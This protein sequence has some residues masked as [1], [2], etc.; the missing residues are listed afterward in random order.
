MYI[1]DTSTGC[2]TNVKIIE[3]SSRITLL[4]TSISVRILFFTCAFVYVLENQKK[5]NGIVVITRF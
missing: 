1:T 5:N 3:K 2:H 4:S